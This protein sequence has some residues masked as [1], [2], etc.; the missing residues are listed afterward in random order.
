MSNNVLRLYRQ[1]LREAQGFAS[2]NVRQYAVRR[3]KEAFRQNKDQQDAAELG[4]L[5]ESAKTNLDILK[6][7]RIV[8]SLYAHP[9]HSIFG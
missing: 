9:E 7:Q 4:K 8:Y 2:Y 3:V 1:M 6:R 5:L